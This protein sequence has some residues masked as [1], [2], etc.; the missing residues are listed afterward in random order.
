VVHVHKPA[1][2]AIA[3]KA[4]PAGAAQR[5]RERF[6]TGA[7]EPEPGRE[8]VRA[9]IVTSWRRSLRMGVV[10]DSLDVPYDA[11][12]P[13]PHRLLDAALPVIDRL[14]T[15]LTDTSATILLANSEAQIIDRWAAKSFL[16]VLD[17]FNVAPG[18]VYAE[19]RVGTNGLGCALEEKRMFEVRGPEHFRESLQSLVCVA[20]P[21]V[22]PTTK[23][24]QG[25]LNVTCTLQDANGLMRP[26]IQQAVADIE[27]RMLE[28]SSLRER[29]LLDAFVARVRHSSHPVFAAS[30]DLVMANVAADQIVTASDRLLLWHWASEALQTRD[31]ASGT[32]DLAELRDVSVVATKVGRARRCSGRSWSCASRRRHLHTVGRVAANDRPAASPVDRRPYAAC[33][34]PS[35][36]V[37]PIR[38]RSS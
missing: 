32:I 4:T 12:A 19:H 28:A 37:R 5:A 16:G 26:L 35:P 38:L 27:R 21:I 3:A 17:R 24:A 36:P 11:S 20:A 29:L 13:T 9:D 7:E 23:V 10:P 25:A 34:A 6:L 22:L 30:S 8:T 33:A 18:F 14:A 15:Q 31:T 1:D 2:R